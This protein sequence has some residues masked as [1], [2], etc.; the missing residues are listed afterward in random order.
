MLVSLIP[1]DRLGDVIILVLTR[2]ISLTGRL[3]DITL[4]LT[5]SISLK[6]L[7]RTDAL[8]TN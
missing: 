2:L 7:V 3:G 5:S 1:N 8:A 4:V 6:L